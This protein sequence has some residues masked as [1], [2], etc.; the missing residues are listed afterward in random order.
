MYRLKLILYIYTHSYICIY[1]RNIC[2]SSC[3]NM[4]KTI[5]VKSFV[6]FQHII[7]CTDKTLW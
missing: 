2:T 4:P 3:M 1:K 5:F 6:A 7:I